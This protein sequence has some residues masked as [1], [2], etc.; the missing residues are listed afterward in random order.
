MR[1]IIKMKT[2]YIIFFT[3]IICITCKG[4]IQPD[5]NGVN[6]CLPSLSIVTVAAFHFAQ[7]IDS[8]D[9]MKSTSQ[10][11]SINGDFWEQ[12]SAD[13]FYYYY[14]EDTFKLSKPT[15]WL[16]V[17]GVTVLMY[18]KENHMIDQITCLDSCKM[19]EMDFDKEGRVIAKYFCDYSKPNDCYSRRYRDGVINS[20][21]IFQPLIYSGIK[22]LDSLYENYKQYKAIPVKD[23]Y[24]DEKGKKIKE[25]EIDRKF[26]FKQ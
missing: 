13:N 8:V 11:D 17:K 24:Y 23:I 18:F 25:R 2:A 12:L 21:T 5:S 14:S 15:L 6:S 16:N 9:N 22:E 26:L 7:N 19:T 1:L 3:S 10:I 20:E 4:Q